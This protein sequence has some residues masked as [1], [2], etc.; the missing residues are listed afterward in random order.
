MKAFKI[1]NFCEKH[2]EEFKA[3]Y[4]YLNNPIYEPIILICLKYIHDDRIKKKNI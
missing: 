4:D 1:E 2:N 3:Y